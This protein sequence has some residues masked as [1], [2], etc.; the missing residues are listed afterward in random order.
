[1]KMQ[2][3]AAVLILAAL[4]ARSQKRDATWTLCVDF[5]ILPRGG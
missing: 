5:V 4:I 1:M 2:S 3:S